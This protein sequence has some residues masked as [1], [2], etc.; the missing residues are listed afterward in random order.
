MKRILVILIILLTAAATAGCA[1]SGF[2][3]VEPSTRGMGGLYTVDP[4][5]PWSASEKGGIEVW[6]VDGPALQ[7][8]KFF[9][10]IE[11]GEPLIEP[12]ESD[13]ERPNFDADMSALEVMELIVD[14]LVA[15]GASDVKARGLR[16]VS[17]G[18]L[19]GYRCELSYL[20]SDGLEA[21]AMVAGTIHSEK[22]YLILY[23]GTRI[24]YF[25]HYQ[26]QVERLIESIR[27]P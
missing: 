24:H 13:E 23:T 1:T 12:E 20:N 4:Q 22:L 26:P 19:E 2:T 10:G 16:P 8:I 5:I 17:F 6:T 27:T 15:D 11:D 21:E 3:L 14:T 9:H 18:N 25:P 7:A